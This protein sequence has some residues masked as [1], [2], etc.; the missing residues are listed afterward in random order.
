VRIRENQGS[1][2]HL[3]MNKAP[4][5]QGLVV[6][7]DQHTVVPDQKARST[8]RMMAMARR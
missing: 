4:V 5:A 3:D 7:V 8:V 1:G 6:V 2:R